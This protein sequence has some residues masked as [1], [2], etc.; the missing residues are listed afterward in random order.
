VLKEPLRTDF[1]NDRPRLLRAVVRPVLTLSFATQCST[2]ALAKKWLLLNHDPPCAL[3]ACRG[4]QGLEDFCGF[5]IH[6][7]PGSRR[8]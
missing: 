2:T 6:V 4:Q 5:N 8:V 1:L 7:A 3:V